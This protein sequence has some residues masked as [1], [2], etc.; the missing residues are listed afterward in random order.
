MA[1]PFAVDETLDE[2][3]FSELIEWYIASRLHGI[4]VASSQGELFTLDKAE[5]IRLLEF[6]V[7]TVKSGF[8]YI[9][10]AVRSPLR[11]DPPYASG[12]SGQRRSRFDRVAAKPSQ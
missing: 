2:A 9:P 4:S 12:G 6:A 7:R 11:I 3:R 10:V 5:H 8:Q 1:T